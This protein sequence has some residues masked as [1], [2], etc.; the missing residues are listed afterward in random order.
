MH[1]APA[2]MGSMEDQDVCSLNLQ[3]D[4]L[5]LQLE[6][7]SWLKRKELSVT[8]GSTNLYLYVVFLAEDCLFGSSIVYLLLIDYIFSI[9][10]KI[11]SC[12]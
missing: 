1:D 5:F 3:A 9:M 11:K 7:I 10:G 6:P 2:N 12:I 8:P 4:R